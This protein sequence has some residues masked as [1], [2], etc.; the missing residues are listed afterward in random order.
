MAGKEL[1]P[2]PTGRTTAWNIARLRRAANLTYADLSRQLEELGR[3]IPPLGLRRIEAGERRVDVDDL[4]ALAVVLEAT[5]NYL[6]LPPVESTAVTAEV[7]A[8]GVVSTR[9]A[10]E[11]A[12]GSWWHPALDGSTT[13]ARERQRHRGPH[14][15]ETEAE[16]A[17]ARERWRQTRIAELTEM[18]NPDL[19]WQN[20]PE[21]GEPISDDTELRARW[22]DELALLERLE[23]ADVAT[24]R[25]EYGFDPVPPQEPVDYQWSPDE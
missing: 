9:N 6:L 12:R 5:P 15:V 4:M 17:R 13:P 1:A 8:Q 18:N 24:W 11:W 16:R 3:P 20:D 14:K 19:L 10:W 22:A 7:T 21:S 2:G 25:Q 23:G